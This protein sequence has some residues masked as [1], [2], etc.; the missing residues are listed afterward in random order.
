MHQLDAREFRDEPS[1]GMERA[2]METVVITEAGQ[3]SL[4]LISWEVFSGL[5]KGTRRAVTFEGL[6]E[7]EKRSLVNARMSPEHDHLDDELDP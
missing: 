7:E 1:T 3:P 6:S 5:R 2:R 4:V